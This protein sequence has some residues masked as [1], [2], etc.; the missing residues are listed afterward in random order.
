MLVAPGVNRCEIK[1]DSVHAYIEQFPQV[2]SLMADKADQLKSNN[3][4]RGITQSDDKNYNSAIINL[5]NEKIM[6][7]IES[8]R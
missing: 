8:I 4:L 5:H 2:L 7:V 1:A 6:E 3:Y